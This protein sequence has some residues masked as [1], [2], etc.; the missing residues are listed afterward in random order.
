MFLLVMTTPS[1]LK[2]GGG[3][4]MWSGTYAVTQG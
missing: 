2:N 4:A 1:P 3:E